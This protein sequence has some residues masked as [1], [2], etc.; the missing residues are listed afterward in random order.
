[1]TIVRSNSHDEFIHAAAERA[2][3]TAKEK[4]AAVVLDR[5]GTEVLVHKTDVPTAVVDRYF[6]A[7]RAGAHR[8]Q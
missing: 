4:A 5:H 8:I 7:I 3:L 2:I 6:A 1:M